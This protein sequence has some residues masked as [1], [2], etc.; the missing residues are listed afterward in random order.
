MSWYEWLFLGLAI[1]I[2]VVLFFWFRF[3]VRA[4]RDRA[5]ESGS[6]EE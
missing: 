4:E 5:D 2:G 6:E 3:L 1:L